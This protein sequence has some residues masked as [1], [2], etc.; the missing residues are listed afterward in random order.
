M[1]RR[2]KLRIRSRWSRIVRNS[3][4]MSG[5]RAGRWGDA[6]RE[7]LAPRRVRGSQGRGQGGPGLR[8]G[9][10]LGLRGQHLEQDR[11]GHEVEVEIEVR[12]AE[13]GA[14]DEIGVER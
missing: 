14:G 6:G 3:S 5:P 9:G 2:A 7:P 8:S 11:S 4:S 1:S 13:E 12:D 10:L